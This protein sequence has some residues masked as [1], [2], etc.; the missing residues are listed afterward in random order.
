MVAFED[1]LDWCSLWAVKRDTA[2]ALPAYAL[3]PNQS[4][5]VVRFTRPVGK[6]LPY[7]LANAVM[8]DSTGNPLKIVLGWADPTDSSRLVFLTETQ[9]SL[10]HY[11]LRF[12]GD[13]TELRFAG[14]V[15][16]DTVGPRLVLFTPKPSSREAAATPAGWLA[17]DD[18]L[19]GPPADGVISLTKMDSIAVPIRTEW[20]AVNVIRWT[21]LEEVGPGVRCKISAALGEIRDRAGRASAD[22][23]WSA[24]FE[25]ADPT[26]LGSIS[27]RVRAQ[28]GR[29]II[30]AAR[31]TGGF[32]SAPKQVPVGDDGAFKI[33]GLEP[34]R[35]LV[36]IWFDLNNDAQFTPGEMDPFTFAEPFVYY[37]DTLTVRARWESGGVEI[38]APWK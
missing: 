34:G 37:T 17:F 22:T 28:K 32:R 25:T 2:E 21:G 29:P 36:W 13:S 24:G 26:A 5:A 12:A 6:R 7:F 9:D 3:A 15:I 10:A 20:E 23:V 38:R 11:E 4:H 30:A 33:T 16:P 18:A 8:S 35:Y 31:Q 14:A 27:G 1:T 19:T